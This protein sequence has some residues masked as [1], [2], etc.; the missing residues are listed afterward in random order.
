MQVS[1]E[2]GEGLERRMRIDLPFERIQGEVDKRLGDI[3]RSARLPGFRPG[4]VPMRVLRQRYGVQVE[5][6]VFG[7]L[8]QSTFSAAVSEHSLR[9]AGMPRIEPEVDQ[10]AKQF[11]YTATFEVLPQ[12]EL[13]PLSGQVIKRPVAEVTDA[14][15]DAVIERLRTQRQSWVPVER[16]SQVGDRVTISYV[17]TLD[18][19]PFAGGSASGSPLELG[20][21]RM[22]PGFEEGV[23][24]AVAGETRTLDLSFPQDYQRTE[25][26]GRAVRFEVTIDAVSEPCVARA[27]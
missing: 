23:A 9:L 19:E 27:G 1:V 24:G 8:V 3:A 20:S 6:E 26:A 13:A 12:V 4:K 25:L 18:G 17:G 11:S 14:D 16:P 2:T 21:G 22:I 7:E 15:L 10:A 5:R